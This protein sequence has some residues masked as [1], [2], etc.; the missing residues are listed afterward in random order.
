MQVLRRVEEIEARSRGVAADVVVVGAGYAGVELATT[1][2]ERLGSR[3]AVQLV[4]AG[5]SSLL[6]PSNLVN[7]G[8]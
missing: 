3:A 1:V 2:A 5:P 4:S 6:I 7:K 8:F